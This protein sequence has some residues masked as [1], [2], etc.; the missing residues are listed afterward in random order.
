MKKIAKLCFII[1]FV[2]NITVAM[3][4][5]KSAL[6]VSKMW[7]QYPHNARDEYGNTFWHQLACGSEHFIDWS[8]VTIKEKLFKF[9][10]NKWTPNPFIENKNNKTAR[11]E[12]KYVFKRSK[13]PVAGLLVVYLRQQEENFLYKIAVKEYRD[14]MPTLQYVDY[15][16][17]ECLPIDQVKSLVIGYG[18]QPK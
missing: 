10:H 9:N 1:I 11:Q 17:V 4:N 18:A 15:E 2:V 8:E 14:A 6:D 7:L 13:N 16:L 12:V 5:Q 3:D